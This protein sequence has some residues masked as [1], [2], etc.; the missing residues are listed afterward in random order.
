MRSVDDSDFD[1]WVV[2]NRVRLHKTAFLISGDWHLA[3]DLVQD[4]LVRCLPKWKR[5]VGSGSPDAYVRQALVRLCVD[6]T[7][8]PSRRETPVEAMTEP[9]QASAP[10]FDHLL[11]ALQTIPTGQRAILVLRYWDGLSIE[12]TAEAIRT[13]VGNVKS[14]SSRGM[15]ALR[16]ALGSTES[17]E[18]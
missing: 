14:Q 6:H 10:D 16:S 3:D 11:E 17:K 2:H 1:E 18:A 8:R 9:H 7:R 5:I 12:E 4:A 15:Q 13:S